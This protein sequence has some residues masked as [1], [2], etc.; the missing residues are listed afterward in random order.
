MAAPEDER[1]RKLS[2]EDKRGDATFGAD[3]D[4]DDEDEEDKD[5]ADNE[6]EDEGDNGGR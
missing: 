1:G 3:G 2:G 6:G 5:D 4:S